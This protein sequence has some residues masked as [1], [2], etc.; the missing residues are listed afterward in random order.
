MHLYYVQRAND[1][2]AGPFTKK[3]IK[4]DLAAGRWTFDV[5]VCLEGE[6]RWHRLEQVRALASL[7]PGRSMWL[8]VS[9]AFC[10]L[11]GAGN[12]VLLALVVALALQ[13]GRVTPSEA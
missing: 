8:K 5:K 2:P 4:E 13:D 11:A 3:E 7:V 6:S 1:S 10:A 9:T 12:V